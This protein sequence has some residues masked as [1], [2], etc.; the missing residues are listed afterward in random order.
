M[1][2]VLA[3]E[4]GGGAMEMIIIIRVNDGGTEWMVALSVCFVVGVGI[5]YTRSNSLFSL[6]LCAQGVDDRHGH[7]VR[8]SYFLASLLPRFGFFIT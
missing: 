3:E 4:V 8:R 1:K 5:G 2:W 6:L 7:T